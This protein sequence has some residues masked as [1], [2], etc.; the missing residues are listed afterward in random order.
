MQANGIARAVVTGAAGFLGVHLR[1]ALEAQGTSVLP[2]VREV[3]PGGPAGA[4][5]LSA[6]LADP[7]LLEGYDVLIH[8]AAV[9]HRHGVSATAYRASNVDLV[10]DLLNACAGRVRRFVLISSVGVYGFPSRLPIRED[11]PFSPRTL[12]GVTKVEAEKIVRASAPALGIEFSIVRPTIVYGR[13]DRNG[14]LDKLERMI[15]AGKYRLVGDGQNTLHHTH[16]DDI[17]AGV[18]LACSSAAA[19]GED[20]ILAGP[21]TITLER[22]SRLVARAVGK[23]LAGPAVPLALARAVG[24]VFDVMTYR[25]L[26]FGDREPPINGEKLDVM[27]RAIAFEP[28]KARRVLGFH[29]LVNYEAGIARTIGRA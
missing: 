4:V 3:V 18:L 26:V 23:P 5:A 17:C 16:I 6:V 1:Q 11:H 8:A 14:M 9:R 27:T 28:A 22:L 2:V 13:G 10:Q 21:E 19:A 25:G 7:A 20:F 15:A 24:S 12:Y 29:P